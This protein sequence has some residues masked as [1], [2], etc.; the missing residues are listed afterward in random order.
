MHLLIKLLTDDKLITIEKLVE[1]FAKYLIDDD[2]HG[3]GNILQR[4]SPMKSGP[5]VA[6]PSPI[7]LKRHDQDL[8]IDDFMVFAIPIL[9]PKIKTTLETLCHKYNEAYS[10]DKKRFKLYEYSSSNGSSGTKAYSL[11]H[12][13][14]SFL[15]GRATNPIISGSAEE[16]DHRAY[17]L[18]TW[19]R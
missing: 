9:D 2:Y 16:G 6:K 14:M 10:E 3:K 1:E 12:Q 17:G 13:I 5:G 11:E 19:G 4:I 18:Q 8:A 15:T 7:A